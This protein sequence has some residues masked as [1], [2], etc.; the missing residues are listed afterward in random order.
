VTAAVHCTPPSLVF[1]TVPQRLTLS[2]LTQSPDVVRRFITALHSY[3][4]LPSRQQSWHR[5][6]ARAAGIE[7][8]ERFAI[9]GPMPRSVA[10]F[11]VPNFLQ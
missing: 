9:W 10:F 3:V 2:E 11:A 1:H 8:I 4:S 6:L 7:R 5:S